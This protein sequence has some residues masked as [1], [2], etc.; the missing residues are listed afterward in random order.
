MRL[1]LKIITRWCE[2]NRIIYRAYVNPG[3]HLK[4]EEMDDKWTQMK[5]S[6]SN[7]YF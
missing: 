2:V 1:K 5:N 4:I 7:F 6:V 3:F